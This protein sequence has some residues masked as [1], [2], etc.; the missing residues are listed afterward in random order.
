MHRL[1]FLQLAILVIGIILSGLAYA[2]DEDEIRA[3]KGLVFVEPSSVTSME[4]QEEYKLV[5][6][7]ERRHP[8]GFAFS[9]GYSTYEPVYYEPDFSP[10]GFSDVY[11]SAELPLLELVITVKRNLSIGSVGMEFG[12]G[13][14][15]NSSDNK[16]LSDSS[17]TLIPLRAGGVFHLDALTPEPMFV[18]YLGGGAYTIIF[19][20]ELDG[21]SSH[22]GNTQVAA[23]FHGGVGFSLSWLDREGARQAFQESGVESTYAYLELQK[24]MA[25]SNTVDG[26][27]SNDVS[28]AGGI[29]IEF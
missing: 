3:K 9:F 14:Y 22:N 20:E 13:S 21:G 5:P 8:W 6:Y 18:P 23:Y 1:K 24:Y 11:K 17:L 12:A 19:R 7:L 10:V 27:F 28:Y 29:K 16:E 4:V 2:E 15:Q 25:S 26:D